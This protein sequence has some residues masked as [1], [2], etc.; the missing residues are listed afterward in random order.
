MLA[1]R[2]VHEKTILQQIGSLP[3]LLG[4]LDFAHLAAKQECKLLL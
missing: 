2:C 3:I 1:A 4:V